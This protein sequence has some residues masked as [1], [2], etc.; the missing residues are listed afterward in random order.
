MSM[1]MGRD[2]ADT[3]RDIARARELFEPIA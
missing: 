2:D 3:I 1:G